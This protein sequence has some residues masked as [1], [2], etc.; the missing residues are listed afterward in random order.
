LAFDDAVG[1]TLE[2]NGVSMDEA[3]S[4]KVARA[5]AIPDGVK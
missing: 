2:E 3:E 4:G 1:K 5:S